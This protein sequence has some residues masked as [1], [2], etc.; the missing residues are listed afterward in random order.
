M[1]RDPGNPA[2]TVGLSF[3]GK[4][5][6]NSLQVID[7][8]TEVTFSSEAE[9]S[10][11]GALHANW[12]NVSFNHSDQTVFAGLGKDQRET[13]F[14]VGTQTI[15]VGAAS[16]PRIFDLEVR[17]AVFEPQLIELLASGA[18]NPSRILESMKA[19]QAIRGLVRTN[20]QLGKEISEDITLVDGLSTQEEALATTLAYSPDQESKV[21]TWMQRITGVGFKTELIPSQRIRPV[22]IS[23]RGNVNLAA[24]GFGTNALIGL[25][26]QLTRSESEYCLTGAAGKPRSLGVNHSCRSSMVSHRCSVNPVTFS[27]GLGTL[28]ACG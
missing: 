25:L 2:L 16:W 22:A 18:D 12:G 11:D 15:L 3:S 24:E 7:K 28:G 6:S 19:I 13:R 5:G 8:K 17:G 27:T 14:K 9:F 20:Y 1:H 21:S 26:L 10:P 23:T 4:V